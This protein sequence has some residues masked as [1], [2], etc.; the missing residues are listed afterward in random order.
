MKKI[1][2][3]G[4]SGINIYFYTDSSGIKV[5][6]KETTTKEQIIRLKTQYQKH[7]FL[8]NKKN[9]LFHIP[10]VLNKGYKNGHFFY[11]YQYIEG[12]S[13]MEVLI[14]KPTEKLILLLDKLVLIVKYFSTQN[15]YYENFYQGRHFKYALKEKILNV[16]NK[17]N[18]SEK[19]KI[20]LLT[21][22][23]ALNTPQ[24][25]TLSHGDLSF[26]N[27]I[28][29]KKNNVWLIDYI[30]TFYPHYWLDIAKLFQD[31]EG[32]WYQL[33]HGGIVDKNKVNKLTNHLKKKIYTLDRDYLKN[34]NFLMSIIFLRILPYLKSN[35][36]K[37]KIL[38]KINAYL[39]KE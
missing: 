37:R 17:E 26:D 36:K 20:K 2:L 12:S 39:E 3:K 15:K 28:V 21:K 22:L 32:G 33:K 13:M 5:V 30:G 11:E 27:I 10:K 9:A 18:L 19:L 6:R 7:I 25:K 31:I 4:S 1:L 23:K 8:L 14:N 38:K 35:S 34:H 24:N 29:D 16:S